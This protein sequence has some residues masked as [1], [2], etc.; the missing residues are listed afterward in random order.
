MKSY[1]AICGSSHEEGGPCLSEGTQAVGDMSPTK[2]KTGKAE[3]ERADASAART[4]AYVLGGL[5]LL[6][7]VCWL[8]FKFV[9]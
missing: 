6:V 8:I 7:L 2:A 5:V 1:C 3:L 4:S 9:V